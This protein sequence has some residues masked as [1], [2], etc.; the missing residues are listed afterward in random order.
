MKSEKQKKKEALYKEKEKE[1]KSKFKFKKI[2][3]KCLQM[4]DRIRDI[5]EKHI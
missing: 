3:Y 5:N 4:K 2:F 1:K